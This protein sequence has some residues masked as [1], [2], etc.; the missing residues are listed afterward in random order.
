MKKP[1]KIPAQGSSRDQL[2]KALILAADGLG[3]TIIMD[4]EGGWNS[5]CSGMVVG[6]KE[7]VAKFTEDAAVD[8]VEIDL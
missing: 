1:M 7:F 3:W 8:E 5:N 2:L 4:S 6:T